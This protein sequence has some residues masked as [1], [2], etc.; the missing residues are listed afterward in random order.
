[1]IRTITSILV[2]LVVGNG[3]LRAQDVSFPGDTLSLEAL[4]NTRINSATK[5]WET[6][7]ESPAS[8]TII[9]AQQI[10]RFGYQTLAEVLDAVRGFATSYDRNYAYVG[11]RGFGRPTDYSNRV[12]LLLNGTTVNESCYGSAPMGTDFALDLSLVERIEVVRGPNSTLY[13]TG[14]MFAT[15]NVVTKDGASVD[16]LEV[17]GGIG[18][19]SHYRGSV[20]YGHRFDTGLDLAVSGS[21]GDVRGQDL[22][23]HEFDAPESNA[24]RVMGMDW[25]T[26]AG[27]TARLTYGGVSFH[28]LYSDRRKGV[29]TASYG[30]IFNNDVYE[31]RDR[32]GVAEARWDHDLSASVQSSVRVFFNHYLGDGTYPYPGLEEYDAGESDYLGAEARMQWDVLVSNR[33]VAGMEYQDHLRVRFL[34]RD[35]GVTLA[36]SDHPFTLFSLYVEDE[37]QVTDDVT[38]LAGVRRDEYSTVGSA[39]SPRAAAIITPF[40][41]AVVKLLYGQGFR[42]PNMYERWYSDSATSMI[43]NPG[44]KPERIATYELVWEQRISTG[45]HA[46]ISLYQYDLKDVIEQAT[47][48]A[49]GEQQFQNISQVRTRG[50]ELDCT[51]EPLPGVLL[52]ANYAWQ[53]A[54]ERG[55]D[56]ALTN[57]PRHLAKAGVAFPLLD[58]AQVAIE[59][60][61]ESGRKTIRANQTR[62]F[63]LANITLTSQPLFDLLRVTLGIRN[64]FNTAYEYPGGLEH[65]QD[66]LLQDGRTWFLSMTWKL[67]P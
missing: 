52:Y 35:H 45:I 36:E 65:L 67:Q 2:L 37:W 21:I 46:S 12:T 51:A 19:F 38:L 47:V 41:G 16:G 42:A 7:N 14:A 5:Q 29:P 50:L 26:H 33:I 11:I 59:G 15:I 39:T 64:L 23:F 55:T 61:F 31:T 17:N 8:I 1:M 20:H 54:T 9:T 57:S 43:A 28:A 34:Q 6:V 60:R 40:D 58:V 30:T 48:P 56:S 4:L 22:F 66:S 3:T 13:G 27:V 49:T 10:K 32:I 63:A 18:S 62:D 25:D 44:I 24:G 53:H